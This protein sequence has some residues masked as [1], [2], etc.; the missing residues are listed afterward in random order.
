[1]RRK[2]RR[3]K[4]RRGEGNEPTSSQDGVDDPWNGGRVETCDGREV[5]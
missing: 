4:E 1:M 2:K 5:T 3:G